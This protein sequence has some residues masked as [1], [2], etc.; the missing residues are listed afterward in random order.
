MR[1]GHESGDGADN[2]V[3]RFILSNLHPLKVVID[4]MEQKRNI[5]ASNS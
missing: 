2:E 5:P 3:L 4:I 1:F